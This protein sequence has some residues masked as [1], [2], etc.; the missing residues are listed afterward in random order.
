M[1]GNAKTVLGWIFVL[2]LMAV[3]VGGCGDFRRQAEEARARLDDAVERAQVAE[4]AAARNAAQIVD[5]NHRMDALEAALDELQAETARSA[6]D[7][8]QTRDE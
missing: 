2:G 7:S 3:L 4:D 6:E 1:R 5:L 8:P